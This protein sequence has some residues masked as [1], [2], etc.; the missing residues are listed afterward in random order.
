MQKL[1]NILETGNSL[2][3]P[4]FS[5]AMLEI[6][7]KIRNKILKWVDDNIDRKD[8]YWGPKEDLGITLES[9]V[10]IMY[11]YTTN[12]ILE[13]QNSFKGYHKDDVKFTLGKMKIF[14]HSNYDVLYI[15]VK[16]GDLRN[17]NK[18]TSNS[19]LKI[20]IWRDDYKNGEYFNT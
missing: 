7:R 17:L 13:I 16:S 8:V 14:S 2:V 15:D 9:H 11:G 10:T 1:D 20:E 19:G 4:D 5:C 3:D 12:D 6:D 18:L